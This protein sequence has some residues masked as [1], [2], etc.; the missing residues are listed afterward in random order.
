MVEAP[1]ALPAPH[2]EQARAP[3]GPAGR[4]HQL[5]A[6]RERSMDAVGHGAP[7]DAQTAARLRAP[8][9]RLNYISV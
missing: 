5:S 9:A 2:V 8:E 6:R 1:E 4:G 3:L 7:E